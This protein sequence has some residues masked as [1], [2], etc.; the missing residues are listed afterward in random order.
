MQT[1]P[2]AKLGATKSSRLAV[3]ALDLIPQAVQVETAGSDH[4]VYA[5]AHAART[6]PGAASGVVKSTTTSLSAS[7]SASGIS[8]EGSARPAS[9]MSSAPSTASTTA[10]PMRPA[11]PETLTRITPLPAPR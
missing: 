1:A 5:R 3:R 4:G 8:S 11:A 10:C 9:S 2:I 6:F 7:T